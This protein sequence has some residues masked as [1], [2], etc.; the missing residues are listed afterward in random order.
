MLRRIILLEIAALVSAIS[1]PKTPL[2]YVLGPDDQITIHVPD[3]PEIENRFV[4][5]DSNGMINLALAG[6]LKVSGQTVDQVR[7]LVETRLRAYLQNPVVTVT[8]T[9]YRSQPVSVLGAV[10]QPG[11]QQVHG[12]KTLFEVLSMA[13]GLRN[14]AGNL[15]KITRRKEAG[16]LPLAD[17]TLDAKGEFYVGQVR[18]RSVM[19]ADNPEENIL[20]LP[21]DVISVPRAE[22]VYVIGA[23]KRSGGFVLNER[24]NMSVLQ[25]LS[26]AEGLDRQA[27]PGQA[28]IL[29]PGTDG[30]REEIPINIGRVLSGALPDKELRANDILFIPTSVAKNASMRAIEAAIQLGTGVV[31]WRR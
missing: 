10:N 22:C 27:S 5:V 18:I 14:D 12:P 9:E 3:L 28:K 2:A 24:E 29:R 30:Q 7:A 25:A 13:G 8:V 16:E 6:D 11:V 15:L 19:Q 20:I 4:R 1:Q 23:V 26:L 21:H 17:K 31:I